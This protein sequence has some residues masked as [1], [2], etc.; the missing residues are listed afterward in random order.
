M[1]LL[2]SERWLSKFADL[3]RAIP[4]NCSP[5]LAGGKRK[6]WAGQNYLNKGMAVYISEALLCITLER[7]FLY[8]L[9]GL[10]PLKL[11]TLN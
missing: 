10:T 2:L 6:T 7:N 9:Q 1:I 5:M 3:E 8:P 4:C 11:S